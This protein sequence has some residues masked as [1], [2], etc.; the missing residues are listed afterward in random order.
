MR[1]Y[2]ARPSSS[3]RFKTVDSNCHLG[4][5]GWQKASGYNWRALVEADIGRWKRVIGHAHTAVFSNHLQM[6]VTRCGRCLGRRARHRGRPRC[7]YD[8]GLGMAG[9]DLAVDAV[10][11]VCAI[12]GQRSDITINLVEQ[13]TDL[14][15][16]IDIV[17]A[18]AE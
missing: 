3:K 15:A 16:V 14:R 10:L 1:T 5:L 9:R 2:V 8:C 6:P 11:V 13:G 17:I 7:H 12:A 18:R 4:C